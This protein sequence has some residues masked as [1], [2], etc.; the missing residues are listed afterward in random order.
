MAPEAVAGLLKVREEWMAKALESAVEEP[1]GWRIL[2]L[3][4][5]R[6]EFALDPLLQMG[7]KVEVLE[8]AD[9]RRQISGIVR[10]AA[11]LYDA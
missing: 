10:R 8:P 3:D 7:D 5:E 9:L 11:M 4:Y 6:P 1:N 2:T